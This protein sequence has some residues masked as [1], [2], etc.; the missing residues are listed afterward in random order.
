MSDALQALRTTAAE[1][2]ASGEVGV[3]IGYEPGTNGK[4]RP[5]FARGAADAAR[6]VY[7]EGCWHNLATYLTKGEVRRLGRIALV[8]TPAALRSLLRLAAER[9]VRD[10]EVVALAVGEDA[11]VRR[12]GSVAEVQ[13]YLETVPERLHPAARAEIDRL[14]AMTATER[15]AFWD[16][17][18]ARCVKCY[19]CR[20]ACPMCYCERCTTDCNRP[21]WIPVASHGLG[22]L[23]Y[24]LMRAMHLAGRCV[25]CGNC[26]RA[27]PLGI[28]VHLLAVY[29]EESV[30]RQFGFAGGASAHG[31]YALST[32]RPEDK[33]AFIR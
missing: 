4:R 8:A 2:L 7:D 14:S 32:F 10:D 29:A 19:A 17:Q 18:L 1:M 15:R 31:E 20:A 23:E 6:L 13:A 3:V 24:H 27:C 33:E 12:L 5:L 26:V 30:R 28:P 16:A 11:G 22:N 9:Q 25:E 21:Q